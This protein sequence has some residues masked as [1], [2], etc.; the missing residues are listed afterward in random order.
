EQPS[1][2]VMG[3]SWHDMLAYCRWAGLRLPSEAE[4]EKAARGT[5]GRRWP[6]GN[7]APTEKHC[8]FDSKLDAPSEGGSY[9][10]GTSPY[11]CHDMAGNVWEWC[12]TKWRE[13][14][15]QQA[16]DS[17][18]GKGGRVLRGG[19]FYDSADGVR[20]ARRYWDDPHGRGRIWG[21]RCAQ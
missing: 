12:S 1:Q 14:Y 10:D 15:S 16:D 21:F 11:G 17:L 2:P 4:W 8:N 13:D 9:P 19:S 18:E 7:D 3:V 20:C 5:D 6:W